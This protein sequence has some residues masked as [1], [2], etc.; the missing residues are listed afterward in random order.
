MKVHGQNLIHH[1]RGP[2][3]EDNSPNQQGMAAISIKK[4]KQLPR[5]ASK[6]PPT[7][8]LAPK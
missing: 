1:E 2:L 5:V 3:Q 6:D 8:A 7:L 4:G